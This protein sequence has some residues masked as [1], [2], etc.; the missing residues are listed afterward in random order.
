MDHDKVFKGLTSLREAGIRPKWLVLDDGWQS[1]SNSDA[2]NGERFFFSFCQACWSVHERVVVM[3]KVVYV[4][5]L[6]GVLERVRS[7]ASPLTLEPQKPSCSF[8]VVF[9]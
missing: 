9:F 6:K 7:M 5:G 8:F 2:P 3:V 1:T 4:C